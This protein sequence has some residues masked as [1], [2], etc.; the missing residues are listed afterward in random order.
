MSTLTF[1]KI[2]YYVG[3]NNSHR[4]LG[5]T[6]S[7]VSLLNVGQVR[8]KLYGKS[9]TK[10]GRKFKF[11][12][13]DQVHISKSRRTFKEGYLPSLTQKMDMAKNLMVG[14]YSIS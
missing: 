8:R 3:Y 5:R 12:L 11:K 9:R 1:S 10:P 7:S 13:G 4:S 6:P 14:Y 2:L